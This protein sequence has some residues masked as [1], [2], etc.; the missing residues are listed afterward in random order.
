MINLKLSTQALLAYKIAKTKWMKQK[1]NYICKFTYISNATLLHE[2][3]MSWLRT[4]YAF[5]IYLSIIWTHVCWLSKVKIY[6][7]R[8]RNTA[9]VWSKNSIQQR[10]L[11]GEFWKLRLT[12]YESEFRTNQCANPNLVSVAQEFQFFTSF[13]GK[14]RKKPTR[15]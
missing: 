2:L 10:F 5:V 12:A 1:N 9:I 14:E 4:G 15:L 7:H 6:E 11:G 13:M 8:L 3:V